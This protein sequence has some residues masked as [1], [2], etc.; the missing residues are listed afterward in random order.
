[1]TIFTGDGRGKTTAAIGTAVRAAGHGLR[2][3][4]V[5]FMK[6][7]D[8]VHG[9]V[10]ALQ[11]VSNITMESFGASG[12]AMPGQDNAVHRGAAEA[13]VSFAAGAIESGCYDLIVLDE[14]VSALSF[15]LLPENALLN[16][17]ESRP[18]G[19]ELLLTGRGA[20]AGLLE[21]ADLVTEMHSIKHPF[22]LGI[23]AR[24]GIDY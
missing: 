11:G 7:P 23:A 1:V 5:F 13:A 8:F 9:E 20:S 12:W 3:L 14:A 10:K 19:V 18:A 2:V 15:G 16:L 6:G 22:D 24:A 4:I 17:L 21:K